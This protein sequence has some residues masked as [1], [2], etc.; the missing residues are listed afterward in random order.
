MEDVF[1]DNDMASVMRSRARSNSKAATLVK[2]CGAEGVR[3]KLAEESW[4]A[5][6]VAEI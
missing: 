3:L 5:S 2:S 4:V 1:V 6:A